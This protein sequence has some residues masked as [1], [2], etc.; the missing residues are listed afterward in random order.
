MKF[1]YK[2]KNRKLGFFGFFRSDLNYSNLQRIIYIT[3]KKEN[4]LI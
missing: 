3:R 2:F 4:H 1:I